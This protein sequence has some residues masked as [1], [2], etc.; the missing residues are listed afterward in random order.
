MMPAE[1]DRGFKGVWIPKEI[2]LDDRLNALDKVIMAEIDSLDSSERGCFASNQHL[3]DFCKCSESKVSRSISTLK[4]CG[5]IYLESFDG[6]RRSIKSRIP[7]GSAIGIEDLQGCLGKLPRQ[8]RQ[9][10]EAAEA[11]CL[12]SNLGSS[13]G[14]VEVSKKGDAAKSTP[15]SQKSFDTLIDSYTEDEELR[16]ALRGF[17]QMRCAMRKKP[18]NRAMELLFQKLD[19]LAEDTETKIAILNQSILNGWQGVFPLKGE[20]SR[21]SEKKDDGPKPNWYY[22]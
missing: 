5:Y 12:H 11:I 10:A 15:P 4:E 18:T 22:G 16:E 20:E 6:R 3:A 21:K 14:R 8:D 9:K 2:W 13:P 19:S 17:V 7:K 1:A